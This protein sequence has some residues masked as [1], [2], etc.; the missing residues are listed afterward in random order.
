MRLKATLP[1]AVV[2]AGGLLA[3][4]SPAAAL[5]AGEVSG[6]MD[7]HQ[8]NA[9]IAGALDMAASFYDR[10]GKSQKSKCLMHWYYDDVRS[11]PEIL[12]V[13]ENYKDKEAVDLLYVLIDRHCGK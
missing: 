7:S 4:P 6:K 2:V 5:T 13:F 1:A 8:E 10:A 11:I 9:F 3:L 12:G